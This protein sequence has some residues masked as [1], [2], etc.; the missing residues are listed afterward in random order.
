MFTTHISSTLTVESED[1]DDNIERIDLG[2]P[3]YIRVSY[4][5]VI[6]LAHAKKGVYQT[7]DDGVT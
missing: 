3:H 5:D 2:E 1:D 7:I 4:D 6:Y